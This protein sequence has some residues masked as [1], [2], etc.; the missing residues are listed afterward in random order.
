[1]IASALSLLAKISRALPGVRGRGAL[2]QCLYA[3]VP[4]AR[5][6]EWSIR[7]NRGHTVRLPRS[8]A[9]TWGPA[10]TGTYDEAELDLISRFVGEGCLILDVGAC[11]GL[12]S[13]P[14][15]VLARKRAGR[16]VAFEPVSSNVTVLSRNVV[17]NGL[18]ET[19]AVLP[20][21][22]GS[23]PSRMWARVEAGGLGNAAM[24]AGKVSIG[25]SLADVEIVRLDD[26]PLPADCA[27]RRCGLVK[28][29]V[30]GFEMEVLAGAD[31]FVGRHRPVIFGEFNTWFFDQ[32]GLERHAPQLWAAKHRYR[33][34]EVL[35][36]R[37]R[38]WSDV[39]DI[40]LED[41][42]GDT[43]RGEGSL[44]LVPDELPLG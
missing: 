38:F 5:A 44:L 41:L 27:D 31:S 7:M 16:V 15:A 8:S 34:Y 13:I 36:H 42:K 22:L 10:F 37:R 29:D 35:R 43:T 39:V 2:A 28:L 9:Q 17:A 11:F 12:Y 26:L 14:L 23:R 4:A 30:E 19:I 21:G 20:R 6:G 18:A 24:V 25:D 1:M 33:C 3:K 32:Y 40:G